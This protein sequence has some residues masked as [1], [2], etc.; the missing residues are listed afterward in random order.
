MSGE[1]RGHSTP[2]VS[3]SE[4]GGRNGFALVAALLALILIAALVTG[5]FFA[6]TEETNVGVASA[7]RQL[8]LSAAESAIEMAIAGW[9][10]DSIC[11][12]G[13]TVTRTAAVGGL[14]PPVVVYITRLDS[15]LYW[16]VADATAPSRGSR[17]SRRI[18][19][20]VR[21]PASVDHSIIIDRISERSW[22]ELF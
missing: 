17:V 19:V 10:T 18:G 11:P 20:V 16:I 5:V 2:I 4:P 15:A 14:G 7:E 3:G 8:T 13:G 22:S 12:V 6:A 21:V 1:T 9:S